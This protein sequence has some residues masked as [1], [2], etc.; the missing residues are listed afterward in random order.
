MTDSTTTTVAAAEAPREF[1]GHPRGLATLFFTEMWERFTYYGMRA[2]L[3]LFMTASAAAGGLGM[4]AE[5]AGAIYGLY[6]AGVYLF[7]LPGGWIADRLL[8]QRNAVFWGGVL[9]AAGNL[10]LAIPAGA[11]LTFFGL[12]VITLGVGLLKPNVSVLVG[13]LYK[14]DTGARR[15]AAF[16]I[17]YFG[18]NLGAFI[19]PLIVGTL[20]ETVSW[21]VGFLAAGVAMIIGL[22]QYKVW[23]HWLGD[24]GVH[25]APS[26][27]A[28]RGRSRRTLTIGLAV[29][30]VLVVL[31]F[32][33]L[34]PL[35]VVQ[36]AN[37][38][39]IAMLA[40]AVYFFG[41]VLLFGGL[42]SDEKKRVLV[43]AIFFL[44][45]ALFWAGFEQAGSTFNLFA[46]D[47]TDRSLFGSFFAEGQHP[48]SWYQ[49]VNP[50]FIL[51]LSPVFAWL[52]M[53]LGKR[54]LD[55][56]APA[57]F[58]LGLIQ[59]GL[60]FAVMMVAAE[61]VITSERNVLP[62]W[63]VL[64]Y[65]LHT[66]GELCL[67]PIGLSNVT[68]LAPAR[69]VGQMMGTWFL[70]AAV[71]N[72]AAGL[73]GGHVGGGD[74][75]DMPAQFLRM[76]LIGGGAGVLLLLIARPVRRWMGTASEGRS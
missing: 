2:I 45:A 54:N 48:A 23:G 52:W 31:A 12:F 18:I 47:Y 3:I 15:D 4:S 33:G 57:K 74:V 72:L 22:V 46:R 17:F 61:V 1:L 58:G 7:S 28:E 56:S 76:A 55:P 63:L 30:A 59:L 35:D 34:I 41:Y 29:L 9:I 68:K 60:G 11:S 5:T 37:V 8:G 25:P 66:T 50:I 40:L 64:T 13:E 38:A 14:G 19:A 75:A 73:I 26:S 71:G 21:R 67:S 44:C 32:S 42:K 53:A 49:S 10:V 16:S 27:E 65:L 20:G 51:L 39:G 6:T 62:T 43:I 69:Y 36:I 24:A 70:G